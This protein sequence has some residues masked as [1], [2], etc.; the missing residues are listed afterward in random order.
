VLQY[1]IERRYFHA[2][3][4]EAEQETIL[5]GN[6][7]EA[8]RVIRCTVVGEGAHTF[9]PVSSPWPGI[10]KW[11]DPERARGRDIQALAERFT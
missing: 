11:H 9:H 10:E 3:I 2:L 4:T 8:P 6:A 1:K 7:V 5:F